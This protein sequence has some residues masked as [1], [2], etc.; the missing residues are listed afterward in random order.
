MRPRHRTRWALL[1]PVA[2]LLT[3]GALLTGCALLPSAAEADAP[4][5]TITATD[6]VPTTVHQTRTETATHTTTETTTVA[7]TGADPDDP[8]PLT[9]SLAELFAAAESAAEAAGVVPADPDE[10]GPNGGTSCPV[11]GYNDEEPTGL[12]ADAAAAWHLAK[13]IGTAAGLT[14]CLN[15]GKRSVAQQESIYEQYVTAYG[16]EAANELVLPAEKS[17]HIVGLALDVQPAEAASWLQR[18]DGA[19]GLC[20]MYD[21]EP[22]HFEFH[23]DY[24]V[25]GCPE[26]LPVPP[27]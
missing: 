8:P 17:A 9:L 24:P 22:W 25:T 27:R 11:S 2:V 20:R 5:V 15:D 6:I 23:P 13:R 12:R 19:L 26:R 3:G 7:P 4:A 16:R 18:T 10:A 1:A 14:V 21:N